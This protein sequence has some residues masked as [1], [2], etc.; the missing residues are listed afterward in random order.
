LLLLAATFVWNQNWSEDAEGTNADLAVKAF[1]DA[2][3][4]FGKILCKQ[5]A[6]AALA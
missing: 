2:A 6:A 5:T 1:E 4:M 3:D